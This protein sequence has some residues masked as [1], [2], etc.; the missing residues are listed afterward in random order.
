MEVFVVKNE[1]MTKSSIQVGQTEFEISDSLIRKVYEVV[2]KD[3]PES[4]P[5][6]YHEV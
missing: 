4:Q 3:I 1:H 6:K 2:L 5:S